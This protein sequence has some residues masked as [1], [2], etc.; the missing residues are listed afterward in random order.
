MI[1]LKAMHSFTEN[2]RFSFARNR[3]S[4]LLNEWLNVKF[5]QG[6]I[7]LNLSCRQ[8]SVVYLVSNTNW[9]EAQAHL[10]SKEKHLHGMEYL[11][12]VPPSARLG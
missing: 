4:C 7:G 2:C 9:C 8:I 10:K 12:P 5:P 11:Q 6:H 1:V 3:I